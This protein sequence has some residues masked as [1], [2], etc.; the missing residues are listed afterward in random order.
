MAH[1]LYAT[2]FTA[3]CIHV[4]SA[5]THDACHY[6]NAVLACVVR[7]DVLKD[8]GVIAAILA[9]LIERHL[10]S[11]LK[12]QI[13]PRRIIEDLVTHLLWALVAVALLASK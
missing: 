6:S 9:P 8:T 2:L 10:R 12:Y 11:L 5:T 1:S 13:P 7:S 3:S 4:Q